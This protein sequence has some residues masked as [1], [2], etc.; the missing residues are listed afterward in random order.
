MYLNLTFDVQV[1]FEFD[2]RKRYQKK[3]YMARLFF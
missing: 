3:K 1:P 2:V